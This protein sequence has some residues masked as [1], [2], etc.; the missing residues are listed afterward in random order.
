MV[1]VRRYLPDLSTLVSGH[2]ALGHG[3]Q[4]GLELAALMLD[5]VGLIAPRISA[6]P[7][8][9]AEWTSELLTEVRVGINF[10]GLR[11]V[12]RPLARLAAVGIGGLL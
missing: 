9:D 12:H 7:P 1:E 10:V 6:L 2:A 5:R 8:D 3:S 4:D 11:R